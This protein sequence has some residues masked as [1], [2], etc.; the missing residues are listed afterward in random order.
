MQR[1][2]SAGAALIA[3]AIGDGPKLAIDRFVLAN[4]PGLDHTQEPPENEVLPASEFIVV[5]RPPTKTGYIDENRVAYSM[6]LDSTEGD[7][8]FNWLGICVAEQLVMVAYIPTV[9]K[10]KTV[11]STAG[12]VISRNMVIKCQGM[13]AATPIDAPAESWMFDFQTYIAELI[14]RIDQ[15]ETKFNWVAVTES[16]AALPNQLHVFEDYADLS[17]TLADGQYIEV[18][19]SRTLDIRQGHCRLVCDAPVSTEAG[20]AAT[21]NLKDASRRYILMKA[22]G[23]LKL[24]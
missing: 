5:D 17:V 2:T 11:G 18:A 13:T 23:E 1:I 22:A 20:S 15:L 10:F 6:M 21:V 24:W 16:R 9:N 3:A 4:V 19:I 14:A 8:D 12:N 7:F